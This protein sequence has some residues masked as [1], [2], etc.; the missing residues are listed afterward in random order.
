MLALICLAQ[1][2]GLLTSRANVFRPLHLV[3]GLQGLRLFSEHRLLIIVLTR[4]PNPIE[5]YSTAGSVAEEVYECKENGDED[6]GAKRRQHPYQDA[7]AGRAFIG[8]YID[9]DVGARVG[10]EG[11][12]RWYA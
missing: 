7:F 12:M 10:G 6:S 5:Y 2:K 3:H 8:I 9:I 11:R 4:S 1:S